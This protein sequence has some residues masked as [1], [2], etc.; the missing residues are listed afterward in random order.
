M[1][2]I[3]HRDFSGELIL[4]TL[5]G[6]SPTAPKCAKFVHMLVKKLTDKN[7][8]EQTSNYEMRPKIEVKKN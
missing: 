2:F 7:D 5:K 3:N 8:Y 1:L 4:L 6:V